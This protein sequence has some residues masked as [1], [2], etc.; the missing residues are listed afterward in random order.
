MKKDLLLEYLTSPCSVASIPYWKLKS[1]SIPNNIKIVHNKDFEPNVYADYTDDPYFRLYHD[2]TQVEQPNVDNVEIVVA[3]PDMID[4]FVK[5]INASYNDLSVTKEQMEGYLDTPVYCADLWV[6]LKDKNMG[7]FVGGG[8]ADYDREIGEAIIE[9][10]QVLPT[11]R[12]RGYGKIIVNYLL[13]KMQGMAEFAT[14]SGKVNNATNP[15]KLYRK[16]GFTGN[17]IWHILCKK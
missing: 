6:F 1:I 8:I 12:G 13:S 3:T 2:L 11:Y 10:V 16:C 5:I 15:E 4:I 9:W 17:D 14:V 7:D